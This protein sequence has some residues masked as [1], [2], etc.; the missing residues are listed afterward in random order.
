MHVIVVHFTLDSRH[1]ASF[2]PLMLENARTSRETEPGC[3]QFDVCVDPAKPEFVVLYEV[4]DSAAAFAEHVKSAHFKSFDQ[5]TS[6]MVMTKQV[7]T[8]KRLSP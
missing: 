3:R 4:Y 1:I 7:H 8:L 2:M 6:G 5:A